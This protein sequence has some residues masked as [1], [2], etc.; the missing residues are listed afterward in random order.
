MTI[1]KGVIWDMDGVL[2]DTG[3]IHFQSW[4]NT[5]ANYRV[6]FS[7]EVFNDTFGMNNEGI[8]KLLMGK[9]IDP[10]T[11]KE[12][13]EVKEINFRQ[14][15]RGKVKTLPGALTLLES[16][17]EENIPQAIGSSAPQKNIDA[18]VDELGLNNAFDALV[19]AA[20]MPGKPD[21]AV[22]LTAARR[23]H[24]PAA[25]CIVIEDAIAGVEGALRAGMK[26][27]AIT[28]TNTAGSLHAAHRI[29]NRFDEISFGDL[30]S[31]VNGTSQS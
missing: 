16:I 27:I 22:F 20:E 19:S 3:E 29:I 12:I 10:Q 5:L 11:I 21:P 1:L 13:S 17:R 24:A 31:L 26:C 2:V 7:R 9:D 4:M 28:T 18:I 23:I 6:P 14:V 30:I 15:M 8:L 25:Q